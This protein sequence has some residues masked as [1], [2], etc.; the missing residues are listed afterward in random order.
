LDVPQQLIAEASGFNTVRVHAVV[1]GKNFYHLCDQL[2]LMVWQ[3]NRC[4]LKYVI[5]IKLVMD[6][7]QE[8]NWDFE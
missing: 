4:S 1:M 3:D 8:S 2:G 7:S 6:N 5:C